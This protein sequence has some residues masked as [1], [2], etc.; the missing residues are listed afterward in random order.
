MSYTLKLKEQVEH[1][2]LQSVVTFYNKIKNR[3]IIDSLTLRDQLKCIFYK[4][5]SLDTL[6]WTNNIIK[7]ANSENFPS[8]ADVKPDKLSLLIWYRILIVLGH[9]SEE[10]KKDVLEHIDE[11]ENILN[12]FN[13]SSLLEYTEW[14]CSILIA[15]AWNYFYSDYFRLP[16]D[17]SKGYR[18]LKKSIELVEGNDYKFGLINAMLMYSNF[19][20]FEE[21]Y[22]SC[23]KVLQSCLYISKLIASK[24]RIFATLSNLGECYLELGDIERATKCLKEAYVMNKS[25]GRVS[26][27]GLHL[28]K[29]YEMKGE[30]AS[31]LLYYQETLHQFQKAG[32]YR[33]IMYSMNAIGNLYLQSGET[34]KA[35]KYF[36][37]I[38]TRIPEYCTDCKH[39]V[40]YNLICI[41]LEENNKSLARAYK[42]QLHSYLKQNNFKY[43]EF[44]FQIADALFYK[45]SK[46]F[47]DRVIAQ[48]LYKNILTED[49]PSKVWRVHILG[50]YIE[51]LFD[52][53]Q[54][55]GGSS[56]LKEIKEL[57]DELRDISKSL[58]D[59]NLF[60]NIYL[61][62]AKLLLFEENFN[63]ASKLFESVLNL[64]EEK[65]LTNLKEKIIEEIK[66]R[67][68]FL[69]NMP[70]S[71]QEKIKKLNIDLY[72]LETQKFFDFVHQ[73]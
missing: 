67:E 15:L 71:M 22:K 70:T 14:I 37:Q 35:K 30:F 34:K 64:A 39:H 23:I 59:Y 16:K 1:G 18:Y 46:R 60:F 8:Y 38:L 36:L 26:Y 11:V 21:D 69:I 47:Q 19:Y 72:F 25:I 57:L 44:Y 51:M 61:L 33:G 31:A 12:S 52:E 28:G 3:G 4:I 32:I 62:K 53:Y 43:K 48:N 45:T 63:E 42:T 66:N 56:V 73:T 7:I 58:F 50:H 2:D 65:N 40:L 55:L 5:Y 6:G 29:S 24:E 13:S 10:R 68:D 27:I 41:A 20:F 17:M 9:Y 49:L 54:L